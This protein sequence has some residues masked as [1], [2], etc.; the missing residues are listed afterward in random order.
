MGTAVVAASG[1]GN[2][3]GARSSSVVTPNASPSSRRRSAARAVSESARLRVAAGEPASKPGMS[4]NPSSDAASSAPQAV[5]SR[6]GRSR[7]PHTR[8]TTV[9]A[10]PTLATI[11]AAA[12]RA[13]SARRAIVPCRPA[14]VSAGSSIAPHV[15][16]SASNASSTPRCARA[17]ALA[18]GSQRRNR[19]EPIPTYSKATTRVAVH[20]ASSAR[21]S[22]RSLHGSCPR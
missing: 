2:P 1:L 5:T 6:T 7:R 3:G 11:G 13:S 16:V 21:S 4:A 9:V 12:I 22:S 10:A 18:Y 19:S 8:L 17:C 14:T 15:R 20:I